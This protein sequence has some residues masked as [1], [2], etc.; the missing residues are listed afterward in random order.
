MSTSTLAFDIT[1]FFPS[2]NH[3]L[4]TLIMKKAGFS[5]HIVLFFT[6][7]LVDIKTNYYWNNFM[8]P[9]F[10]VNIGVG[11]SSALSPILSTLYLSLFIYI[12]EN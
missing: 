10:N 1:Q 2:L 3:Q 7:Y 4:L 6:N 9:I 12:L 11:Q 5:N 8:S